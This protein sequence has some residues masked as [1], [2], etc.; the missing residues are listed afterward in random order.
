MRPGGSFS[1]VAQHFNDWLRDMTAFVSGRVTHELMASV[2]PTIDADPNISAQEAEFAVLWR[3][4][5]KI[6]YSRTLSSVDG[7]EVRSEV[8]PAEVA[9]L[10]AE[11]DIVVGGADLAAESA[12]QG[13][14]D[15]YRVYVHPVLIGA[16]RPMFTGATA[17]LRLLGS[18]TFGNGVV[19]LR[20]AVN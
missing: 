8:V 17:D 13:L 19:L 11:G 6:V 2:W 5:R 3:E 14:I 10:T 18:H 7:A 20:Y 4:K 1:K 15:E 9:E 16:G 12:R